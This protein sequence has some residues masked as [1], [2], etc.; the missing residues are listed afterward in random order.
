MTKALLGYYS[1]NTKLQTYHDIQDEI[2]GQ[3]V[4]NVQFEEQKYNKLFIML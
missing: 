4:G 2:N 3:R 1:Q